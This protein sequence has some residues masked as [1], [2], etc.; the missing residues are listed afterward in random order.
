MSDAQISLTDAKFLDH[1]PEF[2]IGGFCVLAFLGQFRGFDLL[3]FEIF[4]QILS[5]E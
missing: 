1:L 3:T 2:P 5:L 4:P